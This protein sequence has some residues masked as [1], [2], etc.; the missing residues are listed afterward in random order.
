MKKILCFRNSKLG[1]FLISL[2]ALKLIKKKFPNCYIYYLTDKNINVPYLPKKFENIFLVNKFI[3]YEYN[4]KGILNLIFKLRKLKFDYVYSFIDSHNYFRSIRNYIFFTLCNIN[5]KIGFFYK[6]K[7]YSKFNETIQLVHR[8]DENMDLQNIFKLKKFNNFKE[9]PIINGNYITISHGGIS[10]P[11]LWPLSNWEEIIKLILKR[12]KYK[13]V[14]L[15]STKEKKDGS[16]LL[17]KKQNRI[18]SMCGK[19]DIKSL[20]NL[21]KFS[22]LHLTNDNGTMHVAS[23]YDKKSIC[24]FNN[25]DPIGKWFP[26]NKNAHIFRPNEGVEKILPSKVFKKITK[27]I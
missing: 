18:L 2:P 26:L 9:K 12:Y 24:L 15:G 27:L 5:K 10:S 7:D 23:L 20:F 17:K 3:Y 16:K 13:I 14:I 22:K 8:I 25:H 4:F 21:I 19:S 11:K 1:D 6:N